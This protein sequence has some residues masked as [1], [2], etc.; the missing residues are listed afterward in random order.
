VERLRV[1]SQA[2]RIL[3]AVQYPPSGTSRVSHLTPPL[4]P[5]RAVRTAYGPYAACLRSR[6]GAPN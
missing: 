5:G 2:R 4:S 6:V 3:P 1:N